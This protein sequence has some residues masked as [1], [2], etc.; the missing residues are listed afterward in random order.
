MES[1]QVKMQQPVAM[2]NKSKSNRTK[3][4]ADGDNLPAQVV[5]ELSRCDL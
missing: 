1:K 4:L 3:T 2:V 5:I